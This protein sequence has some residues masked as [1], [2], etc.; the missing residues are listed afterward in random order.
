MKE[1]IV[2]GN[3]RGR[4]FDP[5]YHE[6]KNAQRSKTKNKNKNNSGS[7]DYKRNSKNNSHND[8]DGEDDDEDNY[9]D[10][11]NN[12][13]SYEAEDASQSTILSIETGRRRHVVDKNNTD[14]NNV[15][16]AINNKDNKNKHDSHNATGDKSYDSRSSSKDS[17][18]RSSSHSYDRRESAKERWD[19]LDREERQRRER[20]Q[21]DSGKD[22]GTSTRRRRQ[23]SFDDS[24]SNNRSRGRHNDSI[25][26]NTEE[27]S[28]GSNGFGAREGQ[29]STDNHRREFSGQTSQVDAQG[30]TALPPQQL[31]WNGTQSQQMPV[32]PPQPFQQQFSQQPLTFSAPPPMPTMVPAPSM[33]STT[34]VNPATNTMFNHAGVPPPPS[35]LSRQLITVQ[36][37]LQMLAAMKGYLIL[38]MQDVALVLTKQTMADDQREAIEV[39]LLHMKKEYEVY[40]AVENALAQ[41]PDPAAQRDLIEET[42]RCMEQQKGLWAREASEKAVLRER[43]GVPAT[44]TTDGLASIHGNNGTAS[45][46]FLAPQASVQTSAA[47][48]PPADITIPKSS[49]ESAETI[50]FISA[51]S[52]SAETEGMDIMA[53][54]QEQTAPPTIA[55]GSATSI[56]ESTDTI[57]TAATSDAQSSIDLVQKHDLPNI[58]IVKQELESSVSLSLDTPSKPQQQGVKRK[59]EDDE[60]NKETPVRRRTGNKYESRHSSDAILPSLSPS[61]QTQIVVMDDGGDEITPAPLPASIVTPQT[62]EPGSSPTPA[63]SLRWSNS[64]IDGPS[65]TQLVNRLVEE[66]FKQGRQMNDILRR[67]DT[68]NKEQ[69]T[70]VN[71]ISELRCK[72][73]EQQQMTLKRD[74]EARQS[75]VLAMMERNRAEKA[76]MK[77]EI[78]LAMKER[79]EAKCEAATERCEK[80]Q[81]LRKM[82]EL[83]NQVQVLKQQIQQL[84]APTQRYEQQQQQQQQH[85]QQQQEYQR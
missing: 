35:H 38:Q 6:R 62:P 37:N 52:V 18:Q 30:G 79:A 1:Y 68:D 72:M 77:E 7:D 15:R 67:L 69:A 48:P 84:C 63:T 2:M 19:R 85:R 22:A 50:N 12:E 61:M 3:Y 59:P 13:D 4:N 28:R 44:A 81:I 45:S 26:Q 56:S 24:S 42:R 71:E 47:V 51:S 29:H 14:E 76:S 78:A 34:S 25:L 5:K 83:E 57:T 23:D 8:E 16:H 65:L 49:K 70:Q 17:R 46:M 31:A 73:Q 39:Q 27:H 54:K 32:W 75:E 20:N 55:L 82:H 11:E 41:I 9:D 80:E 66:T 53:I 74:L 33:T 64:Q 58:T 40:E 21:E 60:R 10:N 36:D 43:M